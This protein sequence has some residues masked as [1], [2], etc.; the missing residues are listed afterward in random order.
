LAD[1]SSSTDSASDSA[2][3]LVEQFGR[4]KAAF[5]RLIRSHIN[6]ARAEF[7][8]IGA[9]VKRA[10]A[11]A[12][13]A[14]YLLIA[15]SMMIVIGGL[16]FAGEALF[17]SIGWGFLQGTEVLF[18]V[19]VLLVLA[20]IDLSWGRATSSLI[21]AIGVGLVVTGFLLADW[22]WMGNRL[23]VTTLQFSTQLI[24]AG[25]LVGLVGGL[26][27]SGFGRRSA[28][29]GFIGGAVLGVLIRLALGTFAPL[30]VMLA[31]VEG[32]VLFALLGTVLGSGM[33]RGLARVGLGIG[34]IVGALLGLL[35]GV[36]PGP[37]VAAAM[38]VT[39][40]LLFWPAIA[41]LLVFRHGIDMEKLRARFV[42]EQTIATTKETIEWVRQQMPLG[43]KS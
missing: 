15:A 5:I 43:P 38:G 24:V 25:A 34:A 7:S 4:T 23:E 9:Q 14:L 6:M 31:M 11:L 27:G 17:G 35:A 36:V 42:P 22:T 29:T 18:G 39:T 21:I 40:V 1:R 13:G 32:V 2:P 20:I 3:G 41:A 33:S 16:L 10:A 12:A 28:V 19:A 30:W 8:E 37:R 26:V